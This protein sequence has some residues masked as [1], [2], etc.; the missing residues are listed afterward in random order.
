MRKGQ[1]STELLVIVAFVLLVF[2]PLLVMVYFKTNEA[3]Q[4]IASYQAELAV[5]RLASLANSVGS[6]GTDTSVE[7]DVFVP[8]N[9]V[10]L[11]TVN[12][13][14]GQGSEISLEI[15]T[16]QGDSEIVEVMKYPV[17]NPSPPNL[18]D[19]AIAGGWVK[20]RMTSIYDGKVA[21]VKIER[22]S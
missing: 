17:S 15:S 3:N 9:T 4:Q 10:W 18:A 7:T 5:S 8:P 20:I 12:S 13:N 2:V 11:K 21:K 22:V 14:S 1:L 6:L 16:P 19:K